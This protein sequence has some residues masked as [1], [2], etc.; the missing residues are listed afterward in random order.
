MVAAS[1]RAVLLVPSVWDV[2]VVSV[3]AQEDKS[4]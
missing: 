4:S 3:L 2:A 1:P